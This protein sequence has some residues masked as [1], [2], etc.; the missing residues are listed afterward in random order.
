MNRDFKDGGATAI[1]QIA[2]LNR[3]LLTCKLLFNKFVHRLEI[4]VH[5]EPAGDLR[6]VTPEL[7]AQVLALASGPH[8]GTLQSVRLDQFRET[9]IGL[10][11]AMEAKSAAE[12]AKL[13]VQKTI[14]NINGAKD[15]AEKKALKLDEKVS[16]LESTLAKSFLSFIHQLP[17]PPSQCCSF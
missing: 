12:L 15:V 13:G 17:C 3:D 6:N 11:K 14:K 1:L 10:K 2:F 16:A 8:R 9:A 7:A 4:Q 5:I